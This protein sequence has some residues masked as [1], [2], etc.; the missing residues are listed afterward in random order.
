MFQFSCLF[1]FFINFS[2]FNPDTENIAN[3]DAVS[4]KRGN[5]DVVQ[6]KDKILIKNL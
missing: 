6:K 1:T 3:F 2:F 5:F 4:S